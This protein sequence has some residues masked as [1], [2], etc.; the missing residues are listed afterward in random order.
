MKKLRIYIAGPYNPV[1][2]TRSI[3]P[4][5]D[6]SRIAQIHVDKAI[7]IANALIEKGHYIYC[8]HLNHYIHT[9]YSCKKDYLYWWY[10]EDITFLKYWANALFYIEDSYGARKELE[11]AKK[12]K[13]RIFYSLE[14]VP[15]V[16]KN[17]Y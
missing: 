7:E 4:I 11:L 10:K 8:P 12:R 6:A 5:H 17:K 3:S 16:G 2:A 9:H 15:I 1:E 14:K 13:L